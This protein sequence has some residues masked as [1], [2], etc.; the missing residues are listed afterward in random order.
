MEMSA[1]KVIDR[2]LKKLVGQK[3]IRIGPTMNYDW[4]FT[5]EFVI[6]KG[7]TLDGRMKIQYT[8]G[9]F[10]NQEDTLSIDFTDCKWIQS[11]M[12]MKP[13]GNSLNK[14]IGQRITRVKPAVSPRSKGTAPIFLLGSIGSTKGIEYMPFNFNQSE[15]IVDN[16][17]MNE[18]FE[19]AS[20]LV[21]AT[22]HH[23]ILESNTVGGII[24]LPS[25]FANPDDWKPVEE[26]VDVSV[27]D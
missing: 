21:A 19:K 8:E 1:K 3:I 23:V 4:T 27:T 10:S 13:K 26:P 11:S 6:L 24:I 18:S 5:E 16:S 12:A 2:K 14:Y 25:Y 7:F 17:Y 9:T 22:K 20:T 15:Y